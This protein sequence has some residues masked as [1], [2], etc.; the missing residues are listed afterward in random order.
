MSTASPVFLGDRYNIEYDFV[1]EIIADWESINTPSTS[2]TPSPTSS[3]TNVVASTIYA[4]MGALFV[5]E[6]DEDLATEY[7][8]IANYILDNKDAITFLNENKPICNALL[9]FTT[10]MDIRWPAAITLTTALRAQLEIILE[11]K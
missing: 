10:Q 11:T 1:D 7:A 4:G 6:T 3:P 2:R 8:D 5:T 9:A